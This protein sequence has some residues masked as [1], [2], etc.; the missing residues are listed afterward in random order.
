MQ[1]RTHSDAGM[2][3]PFPHHFRKTPQTGDILIH[4]LQGRHPRALG[5]GIEVDRT[6]ELFVGLL[7]VLDERLLVR[8]RVVDQATELIEPLLAQAMKHHVNRRAFFAD[9]QH[10]LPAG[11]IVGDEVGDRLRFACARRTL[12]N[13]ARS[14]ARPRYGGR[15]GGIARNDEVLIREFQRRRRCF[16]G[17]FGCQRKDRVERVAGHVC[18]DEL[19]VIAH[20]R[21]LAIVEI[22]ERLTAQVEI[23]RIWILIIAIPQ[24]KHLSLGLQHCACIRR[25]AGVN[26]MRQAR[27]RRSA[28]RV[29]QRHR[30]GAD[31][32]QEQLQPQRAE[33][34]ALVTVFRF[35]GGLGSAGLNLD[36][37]P[38]LVHTLTGLFV[39]EFNLRPIDFVE[40]DARLA[41]LNLRLE[42]FIELIQRR[43]LQIH[44][45]R[46]V[47]IV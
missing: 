24:R 41:R 26:D 40:Y 38:I 7:E 39:D 15:L 33:V 22:T 28:C 46:Q 14:G 42:R 34:F 45:L 9:E 13:I 30:R 5:A 47:Q 19:R 29:A 18:F 8:L 2:P 25:A 21:H 12:N 11:N 37:P 6:Q 31:S 3:V 36:P 4:R 35:L 27:L 43:L 32:L 16:L 23:P 20:K 17:L 44:K 10:P 1:Q